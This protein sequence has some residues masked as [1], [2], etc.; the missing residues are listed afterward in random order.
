MRK[1]ATRECEQQKAVR[2]KA[3]AGADRV[4][5]Q[6]RLIIFA[7]LVAAT[8]MEVT[9][10]ALIRNGLAER[11][12]AQKA[13]YFAVGAILVFAYGLTL[14]LAPIAFEKVVG[15]YIATL[16]VVWQAVSYVAYR[17]IPG[18]PILV[19]GAFIVCGGLIVAFWQIGE[20]P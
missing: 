13:A 11:A 3:S 15:I 8:T 18:L 6:T 14:N 5:A 2:P 20:Q 1:S 10:D 16:F 17:S 12:L 7:L 4:T 9:G 19:G